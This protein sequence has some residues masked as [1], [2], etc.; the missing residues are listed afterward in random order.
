MLA[1]IT[2]CCRERNLL[3][4][5]REQRTHID[6]PIGALVCGCA[7]RSIGTHMNCDFMCGFCYSYF[8]AL[9]S[10]RMKGEKAFIRQHE[11]AKTQDNHVAPKCDT[12]S[13]WINST[14]LHN[15]KL[16]AYEISMLI[17]V[18][19]REEEALSAEPLRDR[20]AIRKLNYYKPKRSL[21]RPYQN[22]MKEFHAKQKQKIKSP[23]DKVKI[24][25][26]R[27]R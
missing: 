7:R 3:V 2:G 26:R 13:N 25:R 19:E 16:F 12:R 18:N 23:I 1:L 8:S 14:V 22:W 4:Y 11:R 10:V 6:R 9:S 27:Q 24:L 21:V 20:F 5:V 15:A 17:A